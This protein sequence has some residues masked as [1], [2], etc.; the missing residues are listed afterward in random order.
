MLI[1]K[2]SKALSIIFEKLLKF[3]YSNKTT[4]LEI[5]LLDIAN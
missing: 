2:D 1:K 3:K 5:N 4:T